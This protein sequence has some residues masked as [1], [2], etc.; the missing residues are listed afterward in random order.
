MFAKNQLKITV[1]IL[2]KE[3]GEKRL[4]NIKNIL[5]DDTEK[6]EQLQFIIQFHP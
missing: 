6:P 4:R 3:V 2:L 1:I 5:I